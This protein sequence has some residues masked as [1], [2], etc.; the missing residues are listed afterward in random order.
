[1]TLCYV[2]MEVYK[3]VENM[4]PQYMNEM[5]ILKK[6]RHDLGDNSLLERPTG[7]TTW[8]SFKSY[9]AEIW[10]I[11]PTSFKMGISFDTFKTWWQLGQDQPVNVVPA[12][13]LELDFPL[14]PVDDNLT[15]L[16]L[17]VCVKLVLRINVKYCAWRW[18]L[19]FTLVVK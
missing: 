17:F 9:V 2:E 11:L 10:N 3:C 13:C 6:Y 4:N 19:F 14:I 15:N 5:F 8:K 16:Q 18:I 7:S 12:V 1:M